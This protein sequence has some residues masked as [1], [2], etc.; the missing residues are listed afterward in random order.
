MPR[1]LRGAPPAPLC[2]RTYCFRRTSSFR[3]AVQAALDRKDDVLDAD[4]STAMPMSAKRSPP[5]SATNRRITDLVSDDLP[6]NPQPAA[7]AK[8]ELPSTERKPESARRESRN[9]SR[10]GALT[11]RGPILFQ[12]SQRMVLRYQRSSADPGTRQDARR[13]EAAA[14]Q[15]AGRILALQS[16]AVSISTPQSSQLPSLLAG[17]DSCPKRVP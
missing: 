15:T 9:G 3:H 2:V 14:H 5:R 16:D 6:L 8:F 13:S 7:A 12:W 1:Q 4:A 10:L 11:T 17:A